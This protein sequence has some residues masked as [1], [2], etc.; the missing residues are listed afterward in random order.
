MADPNDRW[1]DNNTEVITIDGKSYS[2]YCDKECIFCSVCHE[3]APDHFKM[4]AEED[5]DVCYSQ[6]KNEEEL[7]ICIEALESCPVDAIGF[8]GG[9]GEAPSFNRERFTDWDE[10]Q[11]L[12]DS[13]GQSDENILSEWDDL[14]DDDEEEE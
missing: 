6:P 1:H 2:F 3:V 7:Q 12:E 13:D 14:F 8:D 5:H 10:S 4:G 11:K 9:D